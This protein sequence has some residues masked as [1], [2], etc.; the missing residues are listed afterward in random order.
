M[1]WGGLS[2]YTHGVYQERALPLKQLTSWPHSFDGDSHPLTSAPAPLHAFQPE[3]D[4]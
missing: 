4:T 1:A 3:R 2:R